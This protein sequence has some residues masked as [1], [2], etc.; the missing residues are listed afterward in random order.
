MGGGNGACRMTEERRRYPRKHLLRRG[1]IVFRNGHSVVD[2]IVMD[3][4]DGG[5]RLKMAEWLGVPPTFELRIENGPS[6]DAEVRY[7]DMEHTGV[8]FASAKAA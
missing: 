3:M 1:R 8:A 7:R 4:S 6:L 2:C 5:A